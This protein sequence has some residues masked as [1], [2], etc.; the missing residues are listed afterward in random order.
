MSTSATSLTRKG[1]RT[2]ATCASCASSRLTELAMTLTD[3]SPVR[4]VSCHNCE[5]RTWSQDGDPM[6]FDAV[7]TKTRKNR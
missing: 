4:F 3:G 2:G 7:L 6:G 5:H 1:A